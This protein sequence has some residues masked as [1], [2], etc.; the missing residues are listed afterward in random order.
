MLTIRTCEQDANNT[1]LASG[2]NV[3]VVMSQARTVK[4]QEVVGKGVERRFQGGV[5]S[6][7]R[8]HCKDRTEVDE[9]D[10]DSVFAERST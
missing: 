7:V 2:R 4:K 3:P 1:S 9:W 5:Q 8:N 6:R 10:R